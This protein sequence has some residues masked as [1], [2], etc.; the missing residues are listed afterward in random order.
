MDI[1]AHNKEAA[2]GKFK[3]TLGINKISDMTY[4][5]TKYLRGYKRSN[6]VLR[7]QEYLDI[8]IENV[9][10]YVNWTEKVGTILFC[11]SILLILSLPRNEICVNIMCVRRQ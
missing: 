9:P 7:D 2:N 11:M 1:K 6:T 8:K 4:E 5:E 10:A 3:Y